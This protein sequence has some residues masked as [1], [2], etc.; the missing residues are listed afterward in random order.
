MIIDNTRSKFKYVQNGVESLALLSPGECSESELSG[1][2][3][4]VD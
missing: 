2:T 3:K 1:L 4:P